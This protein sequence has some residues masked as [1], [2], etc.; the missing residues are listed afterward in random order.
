MGEQALAHGKTPPTHE[1]PVHLHHYK[2]LKCILCGGSHKT[3]QCPQKAALNALLAAQRESSQDNSDK[4]ETESH[5]S[6]PFAP[7][8]AMPIARQPNK[9]RMG[10]DES[11]A[12][13]FLLCTWT[14]NGNQAMVDTG[15]SLLPLRR[16]ALDSSWRRIPAA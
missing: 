11:R 12:Y 3:Y 1:A 9:Q 4:S 5:G 7:S 14:S 13:V 6:S 10:A 2:T 8:K 16:S 15:P